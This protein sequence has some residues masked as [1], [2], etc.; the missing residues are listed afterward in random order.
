MYENF[1]IYVKCL[2]QAFRI[3]GRPKQEN[4]E[5]TETEISVQLTETKPKLPKRNLALLKYAI[6]WFF[7]KIIMIKSILQTVVCLVA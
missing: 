4:T 2:Q 3:S 5:T 6:C 1:P 7:S